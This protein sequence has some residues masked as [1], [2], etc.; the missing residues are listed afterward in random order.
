MASPNLSRSDHPSNPPPFLLGITEATLAVET[1][2]S[3]GSVEVVI[4]ER[5]R[6]TET[7]VLAP[8][9][10]ARLAERLLAAAVPLEAA[11]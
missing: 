3:I 2:P 11:L 8:V 4:R 1:N 10:A 7:L 6:V 5:G 9:Q